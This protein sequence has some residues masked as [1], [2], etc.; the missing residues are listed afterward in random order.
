[1][2]R[3]RV[4]FLNR[5]SDLSLQVQLAA[6]LKGLIQ[7]GQMGAGDPLPS[8]REL[9]AE[10]KVSRNTVVYAYERLIS[11]GYLSSRL[12]S[13]VFVSDTAPALR[14]AAQRSQSH[15]D[16]SPVFPVPKTIY[17]AGPKPFRPCQPDVQL[18][19]LALWNRLRGRLLRNTRCSLLH[20]NSDA[21]LGFRPLRE[22]LAAYLRD[23]RGVVCE[24]WQIAITAG[25]QQ[26]LYLLAHLLLKPGDTVIMENP[27]Y[28]G[29]VRAWES[30]SA[31]ICYAPIDEH[32]VVCPPLETTRPSLVYVTP[33]RQFPTGPSLSLARRLALV[34]GAVSTNSWIIEDDYDSE[35]R[36]VAPPL[37]SLQSLDSG[38]RVIY[39]GTFSKLLFPSLRLG[40]AVLPRSLV[41]PFATLKTT[42]ED[43]GP[44]IDQ[45]TLAAFLDSG[46][47]YSHIRRARKN[48]AER[49]HAFL[50]AIEKGDLPLEFRYRDG[51]MNLT[52]FLPSGYNDQ[53]WSARLAASGL[54]VPALSQFARQPAEHGL[55]F[56]F[57]A[58]TPTEI[59]R[60]VEKM[61]S[62]R[63]NHP[64]LPS[65]S[66]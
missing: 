6:R 43:H 61:L 63:L 35:F 12:R 23:S 13:R 41:E 19:P 33:S 47:F 17:S 49:Q 20:Y 4:L 9:A 16:L 40:Y 57:T 29:A 50:H 55:V 14:S 64:V 51:G 52:G 36:Y 34:N 32:G 3:P 53:T 38:N 66:F 28:S 11:E 30:V 60:A 58:F 8:S 42:A 26:A 1:M 10:L 59:R 25:S 7:S 37:P 24:W 22:N 39:V 44:M 65:G 21:V 18:F 62:L 54:D 31:S 2:K 46:A 56:G 15:R 27:G 5:G 48:Y 45:A